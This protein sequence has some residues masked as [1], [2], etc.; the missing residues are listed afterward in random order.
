MF[1]IQLH[2]FF[3]TNSLNTYSNFVIHLLRLLTNICLAFYRFVYFFIRFFIWTSADKISFETNL[4][5]LFLFPTDKNQF[6]YNLFVILH[7]FI[8]LSA[9]NFTFIE[10]LNRI[11]DFFS[12]ISLDGFARVQFIVRL[13]DKKNKFDNQKSKYHKKKRKKKQLNC[14]F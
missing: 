13:G 7:I 8:D 11:F 1:Q 9:F 10:C 14:F 2:R 3:S 12:Y 5:N 4:H 6:F